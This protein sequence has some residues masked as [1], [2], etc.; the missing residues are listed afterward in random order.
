MGTIIPPNNTYIVTGTSYSRL[1]ELRTYVIFTGDSVNNN[2][3]LI[4]SNYLGLGT[5]G[6]DY[7]NSFYN[8]LMVYYIGDIKYTD[9]ILSG[10][11]TGT[12]FVFNS[13][14]TNSPQ[15]LNLP[16][17]KT[18]TKEGIYGNPIIN[19]DILITR[20]ELSAFDLNYKLGYIQNL[21]YLEAYAG[22]GIF[23]IKN[24]T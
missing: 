6:V 23:N 19:N 2:F 18:P 22:G 13:L 4:Y 21:A 24:N 3:N 10:I 1:N 7:N 9:I 17:Y 20:Q 15:Y 11:T 12:T 16:I 14:G 5:D 8:K